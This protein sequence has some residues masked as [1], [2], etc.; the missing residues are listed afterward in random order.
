M[1]FSNRQLRYIFEGLTDDEKYYVL[2]EMPVSVDFLPK[3]SSDEYEGYKI[4]EGE[5]FNGEVVSKRIAEVNKK[6]AKR[7][8]PQ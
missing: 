3:D 8:M 5:K 6:V 7:V 4:P 1:N 2:A